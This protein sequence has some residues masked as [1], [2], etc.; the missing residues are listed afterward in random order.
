[1]LWGKRS[2]GWEVE[3]AGVRGEVDFENAPV[4]PRRHGHGSG[5]QAGDVRRRSQ[6][7]AHRIGTERFIPT[8]MK[9]D[10]DG[11]ARRDADGGVVE[12]QLQ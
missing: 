12:F 11:R 7:H 9:G 6:L 10:F 8:E 2:S 5:A 1:M 4:T 3:G